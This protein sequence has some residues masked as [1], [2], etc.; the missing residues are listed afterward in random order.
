MDRSLETLSSYAASLS[1]KNLSESAIKAAKVRIIDTIGCALGGY[2]SEP[3]KI[4]RSLCFSTGAPLTARVIGSLTRTSTEMAAFA[5]G[6]M[7]R[8]LDF[9]DAYRM[10]DAGHPS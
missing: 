9:N 3:S 6:T 5:N 8:Y 7:L 4:T 2:T 10:K 1:Y